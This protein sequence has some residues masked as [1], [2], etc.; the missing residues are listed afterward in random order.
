MNKSKPIDPFE[1]AKSGTEN[2][3]QT[4]IFMWVQQNLEKYP[5][6]IWLFAIPNGMFTSHKSVAA[7]MRA[8]GMKRG[9]PDIF[10]PVR[11]GNWSGL[12]IELKRREVK[13]KAKGRTSDEQ[14]E[15]IDYLRTQGFGAIVC[16][17]MEEAVK[18][19]IDYLGYKE[20]QPNIKFNQNDKEMFKP[21]MKEIWK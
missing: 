3:E 6:L 11:R 10:F 5:E 2:A 4:A 20:V 12:F 17:G 18:V 13:G 15:W 7:R 8:M 14:D 1:Y 19:L 16:Y 9:V 21:D